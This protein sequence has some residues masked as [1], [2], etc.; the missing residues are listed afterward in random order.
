M[1]ILNCGSFTFTSLIL[2][3]IERDWT[4]SRVGGLGT[5]LIISEPTENPYFIHDPRAPSTV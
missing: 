2:N 4:L 5:Q 3:C 1:K